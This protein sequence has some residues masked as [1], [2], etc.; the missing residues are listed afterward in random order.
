M[1]KRGFT[2]VEILIVITI[3]GI[4]VATLISVFDPVAQIKKGNDTN[5]K[6]DIKQY[7]VAL[8]NYSAENSS[9]YPVRATTV[10]AYTLCSGSGPL[11]SY[12]SGC[13]EDKKYTEDNTYQYSY[14]SDANGLSWVLWAKLQ[15]KTNYWVMCSNGKSGEKSQTGFS[16]SGGSCPI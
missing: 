11:E 4:L 3:I 12:M 16:V 14:Q 6:N 10:K 9:L 2:L 8:E 13:L 7:Q 15:S 1:N 5:R